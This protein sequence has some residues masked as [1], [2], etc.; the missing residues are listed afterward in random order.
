VTEVGKEF[1][2]QPIRIFTIFDVPSREARGEHAHKSLHQLLVCIKGDCSLLV[3][4]G[5]H[6][7]EILLNTPRIGVYLP[8]M[9]WAA[10][11]NFSRDAVLL[12]LASAPYD[13]DDYIRDYEQFLASRKRMRL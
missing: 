10:Q 5:L 11:Y 3:D 6:R 8:P 7:E 13:P 4:D 1:P 2:F 9:I 12:V